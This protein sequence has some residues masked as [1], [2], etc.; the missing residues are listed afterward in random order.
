V[1]IG[2]KMT[3]GVY[4]ITTGKEVEEIDALQVML[5]WAKDNN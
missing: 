1:L 3:D 2:G 5:D 4:E